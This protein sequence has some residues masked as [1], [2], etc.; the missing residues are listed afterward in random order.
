MIQSFGDKLTKSVYDGWSP[1]E[2]RALED[3]A[4]RKL[5]SLDSA[6]ILQDLK[7]PPGNRLEALKEDRKGMYSV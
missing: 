2:Y 3:V 7:S 6:K 1:K 4:R 5:R